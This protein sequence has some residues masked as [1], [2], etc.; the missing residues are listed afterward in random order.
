MIFLIRSIPYYE[1]IGN[2]RNNL[3]FSMK[4]PGFLTTIDLKFVIFSNELL[5]RIYTLNNSF[6]K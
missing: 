4:R 5:C 2:Q 1:D 3:K 6:K